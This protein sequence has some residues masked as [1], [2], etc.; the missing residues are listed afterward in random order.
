MTPDVKIRSAPSRFGLTAKGPNEM[1]HVIP[2]VVNGMGDERRHG[3]HPWP[4]EAAG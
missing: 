1:S 4:Y 2:G 3:N